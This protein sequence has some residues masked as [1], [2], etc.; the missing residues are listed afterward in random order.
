MEEK[1]RNECSDT[2]LMIMG[3]STLTT[4]AD[5]NLATAYDNFYEWGLEDK[6]NNKLDLC[7]TKGVMLKALAFYAEALMV[8]QESTAALAQR[9]QFAVHNDPPKHS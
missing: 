9:G 6:T 4:I 5:P 3:A 2:V 7:C 1:K 8:S